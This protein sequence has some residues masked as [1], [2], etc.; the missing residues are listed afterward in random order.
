MFGVFPPLVGSHLGLMVCF[1]VL[2]IH[3]G[4]QGSVSAGSATYNG[5]MPGFGTQLSDSDNSSVLT[6]IRSQ[7]GNRSLILLQRRR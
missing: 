7:W 3:H 2:W 1:R 4:L 5:A 6:Y